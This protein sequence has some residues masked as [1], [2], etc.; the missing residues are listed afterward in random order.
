M[1]CTVTLALSSSVLGLLKGL[2][3]RSL[4][5]AVVPL[6][7]IAILFS[8]TACT[9]PPAEPF[10][11][12][13]SPWPGYEPLHLARDLG[14]FDDNAVRLIELPT[15]NTTLEAFSNGSADI[16]TLTL[17]ETLTLLSQGRNVRV[18][19]VMDI[20]N[21][22]DAVL[23]RPEIKTLADIKGKRITIMNIPLGVYMLARLLDAAGLQREDVEVITLPEDKHEK[24]Y[25]ANKTDVVITFEPYKTRLQEAGAHV[26]FDS[27]KIPNEV[28][29]L[30]L[31]REDTYLSRREELC[32]FV[33]EWYRALDYMEE[34]PKDAAS[35]MAQRLKMKPEEFLVSM[36]G[37][38]FPDRSE[39]KKLLGG[40]MP[41]LI[42]ISMHLEEIMLQEK[43]ISKRVDIKSAIDPGF[44]NCL[45]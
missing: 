14:Y 15:S 28:F 23:A 18:L 4:L 22:G 36:K 42:R 1:R 21:G 17:D 3:E 38:F 34:H 10:R 11:I 40:A 7:A 37:M 39:N 24:A 13:S 2:F 19:T 29:D 31:V 6:M 25:V 41:E 20:S 45:S 5:V 35:R 33:N 30:L 32:A 16:A 9:K 27:S 43:M 12:V 44:Q 8:V 26:I